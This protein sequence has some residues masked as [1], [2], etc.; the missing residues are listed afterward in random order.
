MRVPSGYFTMSN[1][2]HK[3]IADFHPEEHADIAVSQ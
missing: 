1:I 2:K 3:C